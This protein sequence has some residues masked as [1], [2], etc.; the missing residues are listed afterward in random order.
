MEELY[1]QDSR[2]HKIILLS[3]SSLQISGVIDVI[4]F[5]LNQILLETS[6]G[7]LH[8]KGQDLHVNRITVERGEVDISGSVDSLLYSEVNTYSQKAESFFQRLLK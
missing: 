2:V 6:A 1:K 7:I 5:D 3:R 4:S 8:V